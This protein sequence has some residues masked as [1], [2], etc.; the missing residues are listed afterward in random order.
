MDN[1]IKKNVFLFILI[2][3]I[4]IIN[5]L[6][7]RFFFVD[8]E[9]LLNSFGASI[10]S[11]KAYEFLRMDKRWGFVRHLFTPIGLFVR[12]SVVSLIFYLG[13]YL[14]DVSC[15]L[16]KLFGVVIISEFTFLFFTAL[17]TVLMY[18]QDFTNL[19]EISRFAPFR[20]ISFESISDF[21]VWVKIPLKIVSTI[22]VLYW[23][24]L[25]FLLSRIMFWS[26]I[27]SFLFVLKTYV[28]A[29]TLWIVF[30]IFVNVVLIN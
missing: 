12:V 25:G 11:E 15:S 10:D 6:I 7:L 26:F 9:L 24:V 22:E 18:N 1:T 17:R 29:L 5:S 4:Y 13:F 20:F 2:S 14:L 19:D 28:L 8:D 23:T 21:P 27:R 16:R 3:C 30:L